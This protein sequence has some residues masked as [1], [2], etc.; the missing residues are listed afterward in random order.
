[1]PWRVQK[2][3]DAVHGVIGRGTATKAEH[4]AKLDIL[5]DLL[6]GDLLKLVLG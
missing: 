1:M 3:A 4:H 2:L 5:D 6:G